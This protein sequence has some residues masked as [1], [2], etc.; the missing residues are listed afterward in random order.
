MNH[1]FLHTKIL[2]RIKTAKNILLVAHERPDGDALGSICA[3]MDFL[4]S[5]DKK[6]TAYCF[7]APPINFNYLPHLEK[8]VSDKTK[9]NFLDFD[10]VI[11]FDCG[12]LTRTKLTDE[13]RTRARSQYVI[14]IDHHS[15]TD[16]FADLEIKN[17]RAASTTEIVYD[18][19]HLNKLPINKNVAD[20]LL[21]GI[22]VDTNNF[23]YQSTTDRTINIS[24][25]MLAQ[26]ASL[27]KIMEKTM[28][29]H[30]LKSLKLWG[31]AMSGLEINKKYNLAVTALSKEDL[32]GAA[33]E[34]MDGISNYLGNLQGV[35]G[36]ISLFEREGG[37]IKGSIRSSHPT[38]DISLLAGRFGGGGHAKAAGFV[39]QGQL[40]RNGGKWEII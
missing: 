28:R 10:L 14:N 37:I 29:N 18:F 40:K 15:K 12:D 6:F 38:V 32:A 25:E 17:D 1:N 7:D 27:P 23:L 33:D 5:Q 4:L 36:V 16:D 21:T 3:M 22:S 8:I 31:A 24:S 39:I 19:F 2:A 13:I 30:R 34:D 9:I 35:A 11:V 20:C 26:G